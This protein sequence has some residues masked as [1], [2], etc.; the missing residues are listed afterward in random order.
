MTGWLIRADDDRLLVRTPR[1]FLTDCD[2]MEVR[3]AEPLAAIHLADRLFWILQEHGWEDESYSVA[4]I[5]PSG[6]RYRVSVNG[7][8]C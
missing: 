4:E 1:I 5:A 7:G 8:G 6:I 2:G 3:S